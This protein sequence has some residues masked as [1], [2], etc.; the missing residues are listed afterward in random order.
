M[1]RLLS[2]TTSVPHLSI[3]FVYSSCGA[4]RPFG[5]RITPHDKVIGSCPQAVLV[6]FVMNYAQALDKKMPKCPII[7]FRLGQERQ[8]CWTNGRRFPAVP[9]T[10]LGSYV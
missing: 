5:I 7:A 9:G 6:A 4:K 1:H 8:L 10:I 2:S 3:L